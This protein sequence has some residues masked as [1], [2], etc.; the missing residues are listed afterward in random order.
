MKTSP[1]RLPD[2]SEVTGLLGQAQAL[3]FLRPEQLDRLASDYERGLREE[4]RPLAIALVGATGA[5][6]ST[7]LNALAGRTLAPE[8]VDRPT[9][10]EVTVYA[11]QGATLQRFEGA[12]IE[13]YSLKAAAPWVGQVF[14]D[15]PD[16]NSV[17]P[18]H[19]AIARAALEACDVALVVMHRGS[20]AEA[21]QADFL[22]EF[23]QR[24]RLL[25]VLNFADQLGAQAQAE[26]KAQVR[27]LATERLGVPKEVVQV[28]AVSAVGAKDLRQASVDFLALIEALKR[29]AEAEETRRV[30]HSNASAALEALR[31]EVNLA[32]TQTEEAIHATVEALERGFAQTRP[33]LEDDFA[34]RIDAS[35]GHLHNEV[36]REA[37]ARW[38]G[39]AAWWMRLS[40]LGAGGLGAASVVA[41]ASLPIG[42]AVA[43]TSTALS[44]LQDHTRAAA[45]QERVVAADEDEGETARAARGVVAAARAEALRRGVDPGSLAVPEAPALQSRLRTLREEAWRFTQERAVAQTVARW[46]RWARFLLLPVVNLPLLALGVDVGVRAGRAYLYGPY[47]G[48]DFFLNAGMLALAFSVAGALLASLSLAGMAQRVRS[49]G[50]A[51]FSKAFDDEAERTLAQV[52]EALAGPRAAALTISGVIR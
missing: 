47:L 34:A 50:K 30:R 28:F 33:A 4:D 17:E 20:V 1:A 48:A 24:R 5:G 45:A 6:K 51:R 7:L 15:T 9:S 42:L 2:P 40:L 16:L 32:L 12:A 14:V 35:S 37:A 27:A 52:R 43:A 11:P 3:P 18:S 31:A 26:L 10:R 21:V 49:A 22:G 41:R 19:R 29:L 39:P 25:F 36:R 44:K 46:W 13:R 8:G 23:A 38:W